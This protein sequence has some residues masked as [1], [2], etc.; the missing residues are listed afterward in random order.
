MC[1]CLIDLTVQTGPLYDLCDNTV[2]H[3]TNAFIFD[4]S[5]F[6]PPFNTFVAAWRA[7][8]NPRWCPRACFCPVTVC[9][10]ELQRCAAVLRFTA[11]SELLVR[12][13]SS[14]FF[15]IRAG[16]RKCHLSYRRTDSLTHFVNGGFRHW[17]GFRN[18]HS[19]RGRKAAEDRDV[20]SLMCTF[21]CECTASIQLRNLLPFGFFVGIKRHR[22]RCRAFYPPLNM[23]LMSEESVSHLSPGCVGWGAKQSAVKWNGVSQNRAANRKNAHTK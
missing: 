12:P 4:A 9:A 21:S 8:V 17:R 15:F 13:L 20:V 10:R 3:Q 11:A 16:W 18:I 2:Q 5:R 22:F 6:S 14:F 1:W 19:F 23:L 7:A